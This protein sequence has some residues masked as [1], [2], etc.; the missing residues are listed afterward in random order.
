MAE[1]QLVELSQEHL[2]SLKK[3]GKR[4]FY[5][6][7]KG[8]LNYDWLTD[9]IHKPLCDILQD[10]SNTRVMAVLPRGWLKST[11]C[12]IAFPIWLTAYNP[13]LRV[14]IV[15]NTFGNAVKKLSSIKDQ[16]ESNELLRAMFP[17]CLPGKSNR[18]SSDALELNRKKPSAEATYE[19]AGTKTKV[20]SRHYDLIV[21][22]DT[23]A[24]DLDDLTSNN[25]I[26][27]QDDINQAIGW[28][29]LMYPLLVDMG[30]SRSV[31]VGTRWAQEDLISYVASS[32][33]EYSVYERAAKE[34]KGRIPHPAGECVYPERFNEEVLRQL[35]TS[36]GPYLFACLYMNNPMRSE[37]MVF[38]PEWFRF[39]ASTPSR[40]I[41]FTTVDM[42]IYDEE[43]KAKG[44]PDYSVVLTCGVDI[45]RGE[46]Y[47]FEYSRERCS[48]NR[49]IELIFE[50]YDKYDPAIVGIE[51]V[52]Y[53]R[54]LL[55]YVRE[56]MRRDNKFFTIEPITHGR[57]SKED[58]IKGLQPLF[59]N[60]NIFI[61]RMMEELQ[62]EL[63]SF[64]IGKHDDIIDALSMQMYF[65]NNVTLE[66]PHKEARDK[67]NYKETLQFY[68]DEVEER[69]AG[70]N[71]PGDLFGVPNEGKESWLKL[72]HADLM[73][74]PLQRHFMNK[75]KEPSVQQRYSWFLSR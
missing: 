64:P 20:T 75:A 16:W 14:L 39:Y 18:W 8:I 40:T 52:A 12:T 2:D 49:L 53:Q 46:K 36:M 23:V 54:T 51:S 37:D 72:T 19:C 63:L 13:D 33:K 30:K 38:S 31:V 74:S 28:H 70:V 57:R 4:S 41:N 71:N 24:P 67:P 25:V 22:D 45:Y 10:E 1:D 44:D 32:Q 3:Q 26:P 50:H 61:H 43:R 58:R 48:P 55:Y 59:S 9:K 42:S 27:S 15:Q 21:E 56:K 29:K 65:W 69:L 68:I 35:E 17:E 66:S 5:F 73:V 7:A 47:V 34:L 6:F 62:S 60:H 11:V